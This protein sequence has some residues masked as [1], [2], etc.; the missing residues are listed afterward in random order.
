LV[1]EQKKWKAG[2]DDGALK[3]MSQ[4]VG[5][6]EDYLERKTFS[7]GSEWESESM[8]GLASFSSS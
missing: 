6:I 3:R 8:S 4:E 5:E 7:C 1:K 2:K